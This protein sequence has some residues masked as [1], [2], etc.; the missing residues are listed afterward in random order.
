MDTAKLP[1][2]VL[3]H[4]AGVQ[5]LHGGDRQAMSVAGAEGAGRGHPHI[6]CAPAG[7]GR[8]L[9]PVPVPALHVLGRGRARR[10]ILPTQDTIGAGAGVAP[11]PD[12]RVVEGGVTAKTIFETAAVGQ[13]HRGISCSY[14]FLHIRFDRLSRVVNH[15]YPSTFVILKCTTCESFDLRV[16]RKGY[17]RS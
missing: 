16:Q 2:P 11:V 3:H 8:D 14:P 15:S 1:G 12:L 17:Q 9:T 4:V 10:P 6:L 5:G 13:S 7:H